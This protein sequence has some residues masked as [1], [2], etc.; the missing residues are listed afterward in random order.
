[1]IV[2]SDIVAQWSRRREMLDALAKLTP[3]TLVEHATERSALCAALESAALTA[4]ELAD[5]QQAVLLADEA[6]QRAAARAGLAPMVAIEA[7]SDEWSP[8]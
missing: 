5:V 3:Q 1:V 8:N 7:P 6:I 4:D 2:A